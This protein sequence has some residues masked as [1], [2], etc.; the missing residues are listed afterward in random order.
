MERNKQGNKSLIDLAGEESSGY[1]VAL[2]P[3]KYLQGP[4]VLSQTGKIAADLGEKALVLGGKTALAESWEQIKNS[5]DEQRIGYDIC[6]FGGES[7]AGE[8]E[9]AANRAG[10]IG[11]DLIVGVGGGKA[12]DTAKAAACKTGRKVLIIPTIAST[13]A[14]TSTISVI[15][16]HKGHFLKYYRSRRNPDAVLVDT[17]ILATAPTRYLCAGIG[18]ALAVSYEAEAAANAGALNMAGGLPFSAVIRWATMGRE[19]ILEQARMAKLAADR[20]LV[21]PA[22]EAVVEANLLLSGIGFESGGLAAAHGVYHGF[23]SAAP[24]LKCLHGEIVAF[25]TLVQLVLERRTEA[26]LRSLITLYKTLRLPVCLEEFSLPGPETATLKEAAL[27]A[28]EAGTTKNMP[29]IVD[30]AMMLEAILFVD[31]FGRD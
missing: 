28:C 4:G 21:T 18:G 16:D 30:S 23:R 3:G 7:T 31:A 9:A 22:L 19:L 17:K 1:R 29:F 27:Y 12:I 10:E 26:E 25:G 5:L 20:N 13:D 2:F 8:I 6:G 11:A 15:H 14:S 24:M